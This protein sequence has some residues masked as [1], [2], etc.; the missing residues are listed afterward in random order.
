MVTRLGEA[1]DS[2]LRDPTEV[3][4]PYVDAL[5]EARQRARNEQRFTDADAIRDRLLAA[6]VEIRDTP[7]GTDWGR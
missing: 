2:G 1:A 4:A 7:S 3:I 6:G 5:L